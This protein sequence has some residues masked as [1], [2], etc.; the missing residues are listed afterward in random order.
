MNLL[1]RTDASVAM[2]TGHAMRCLALAQAWIDSGRRAA[3]AMAEATPSI[4][5]RL[6]SERCEALAISAKAG[7]LE[8]AK[9]TIALAHQARS[10]WIVVD[11]YQFTFEYQSA[12]KAAGYKVLFL[13]D[14]GHASRYS[15]DLVLNQNVC[16]R[17]ALYASREAYTRLLLGPRYAL[18][19]RE[20]AQ[21]RGWKR[22]VA[23]TCRRLLVM[24]GG[25]DPENLTG[26][27]ISALERFH[28]LEV[29]V[30]VGGSNPHLA[31]L[32]GHVERS[33]QKITL[34]QDVANMPELMATADVAFSAAGSTC[35]ELC[36]MALPAML[37]D[38]AANQTALAKELDRSGCA[39]HVGD[40]TVSASAIA[41][42]LGRMLGSWELRRLLSQRCRTL[43][44]GG[45][46]GRV[47]SE[48]A[49]G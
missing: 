17:E 46:T 48:L 12:L 16:A 7:D 36:L 2:G 42:V 18:L 1:F 35:W 28:D 29:T 21:W 47:L 4:Q 43:V 19:R 37:I 45:G 30:V 41:E 5:K 39:V 8:D 13:D 9:Q 10:E 38:V 49:P 33:G 32:V 22:E 3:F 25:S 24:M 44:D 27:V 23:S 20:F 31:E 6:A 34:E 14:Y 40:R 15:A 11:G 26:R